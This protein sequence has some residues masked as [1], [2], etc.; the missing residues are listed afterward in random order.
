MAKAKGESRSKS[1]KKPVAKAA[2]P[3]S[4]AA[5]N[6]RP[7]AAKKVE[8]KAALR[9]AEPAKP[10]SARPA[11][12]KATPKPASTKSQTAKQATSTPEPRLTPRAEKQPAPAAS[13]SK[14]APPVEPP[15]PAPVAHEKESPAPESQPAAAARPSPGA[16]TTP[17]LFPPVE[18][19]PG[20]V[21]ELDGVCLPTTRG[22]VGVFGGPRDHSAKPDDKL[23]LPTGRH[24]Q[25]EPVRSLNAKSFYCAMRW[26]YR[27]NHMSPEE[28]KRWWANKK[29]LVTNPETSQSVVVRAVDYGP[30]ENTGLHISISPGAAEALGVEVGSIVDIKF[31]DQRAQLGLFEEQPQNG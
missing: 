17:A 28:G 5:A 25:Y 16:A 20:V 8:T 12:A 14:P 7:A 4:K 21:S 23:A 29:L 26:D 2:K 6:K 18:P 1:V 11:T 3:A 22:R 10:A 30:H 13:P 31:A 24:F 27:Q 19:E 9:S 15:K